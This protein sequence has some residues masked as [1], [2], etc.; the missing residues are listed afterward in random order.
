MSTIKLPKNV[1]S[2]IKKEAVKP[3][4]VEGK[5]EDKPLPRLVGVSFR[6]DRELKANL[7]EILSENKKRR[8][9][10][11]SLTDLLNQ[12]A[13]DYLEKHKKNK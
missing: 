4:W 6:M 10:P 5:P 11:H 9:Y 13:Y 3:Q 1:E 8:A 12:L 7:E 2:L